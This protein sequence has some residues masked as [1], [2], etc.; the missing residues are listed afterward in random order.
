M[1][2]LTLVI[3]SFVVIISG[4]NQNPSGPRWIWPPPEGGH[5]YDLSEA[6]KYPDSVIVLA[7]T[8]E[9]YTTIP[10]EIY[11][12]N[13]LE[14]LILRGNLIREV[15]DSI[16]YFKSLRLLDLSKNR[17]ATFPAAVCSVSNLR[18][19]YLNNNTI[20]Y[21]HPYIGR[22]RKLEALMMN[23]CAL[24]TLT[25]SLT[26][27]VSLQRLWIEGNPI[28]DNSVER[29]QRAMPNLRIYR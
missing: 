26:L 4:C 8:E 25:D 16:Q 28:K 24:E 6:V 18:S 23:E 21:I 14:A 9:G 22:M 20:R 17:L 29:I 2:R 7:L 3:T 1:N 13:N 11:D 15:P 19:L 10:S 27:C 12:F 5:F